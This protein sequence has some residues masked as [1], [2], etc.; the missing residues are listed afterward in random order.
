MI[1]VC[2]DPAGIC[3]I[4]R[5]YI[6]D[7][8][9]LRDWLI[10]EYGPNGFA[11][12]TT[13][14]KDRVAPEYEI[15]LEE[16]ANGY[17]IDND[18]NIIIVHTPQGTIALF[19]IAVVVAVVAVSL[20]SIPSVPEFKQPTESPNNNLSG[21]TNIARPQQRI[22]DVYGKNKVFPD[23]I[24]KTYFEFIN[25][26]KVQNEFMCIG[27]GEYLVE[28]E[29]T[30]NSL[31]AGIAG[32]VSTIFEPFTAPSQLLDV[33]ASNEVNGQ[34]IIGPN[35]AKVNIGSAVT[36]FTDSSTIKSTDVTMATF[37]EM[38]TSELFDISS[39]SVDSVLGSSDI[40]F[41]ATNADEITSSGP[42]LSVF[43]IGDI[44][45]ISGTSSNNVNAKILTVSSGVLKC[46]DP[47]TEVAIVFTNETGTSA[48]ITN[49][50]IN[51][52]TFT[53]SSFSQADIGGGV[54]EFTITVTE[55]TFTVL[56]AH[57]NKY[58]S[59]SF[60]SNE[61][62][63]FNVPGNPD[64]VWFDIQLPKGLQ[65]EGEFFTINLTL[66]LQQIDGGGSPIGTAEDTPIEITENTIDPLFFTFKV[67]PLVIG[68]N[69]IYEASV[70]RSTN[71]ISVAGLSEQTKW[72]RLA[73]V[74]DV[75]VANFGNVTTWFVTTRATEQ[76]TS[77]QER[78][79]NAVVTRK[80]PT[81]NRATGIMTTTTP[82]TARMADAVVDILTNSFMGNK[83]LAQ[84]D[85]VGLYDIQDDLD[86]DVIYGDALGRFCYSFSNSRTPVDDEVNT[87]LRACRSFKFQEGNVI[88][89]GR[90]QLNNIRTT[91]FNRRLKKPDSESKTRKLFKP[92][93]FDGIS[94]EWVDE[95]TGEGETIV[96]PESSTPANP[97]RLE[98]AGVKNYDQAW[99]LGLIN[100]NI[101]QLRRTSVDTTIL[102][103]AL[104]AFPNARVGNVDSTTL[105]TQD[106][107]IKAINGLTVTTVDDIDFQGF[108]TSTVI[109]RD[110]SGGAS[111]PIVVTEIP[112]DSKGFILSSLPSFNIFIR[113]DILEG[114]AIQMGTLYDFA[115]DSNHLANDYLVQA[116]AP[117]SDGYVNVKLLNYDEDVYIPDTTTPTPRS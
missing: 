2:N 8:T 45:Q 36:R 105:K 48:A 20:V 64:Q 95:N 51:A 10:E 71:T 88:K 31:L 80:L 91:T 109:L 33:T 1:L 49:T 76:A 111:N 81:F 68:D 38:V 37:E 70:L 114:S 28:E 30:G 77:I 65:N 54:T 26:V 93:D 103:D 17:P 11:V 96:F 101:L 79:F 116:I 72:T 102:E 18:D 6:A 39:P 66:R 35:V 23:L 27:R 47:V 63:P 98:A 92:N 74:E 86:S 29:K 113:G 90:D 73:G 25:Q 94:L 22:P 52:G 43:S 56:S 78:K 107:E 104:L 13:I 19:I 7:D 110:K 58:V 14:F 115:P 44:I 83:P 9:L 61:I 46:V 15:K 41:A 60:K 100:F 59:Q 3:D 53:F 67:I 87:A 85:L 97:Q 57:P 40:D 21:Q 84:I 50:V 55:T 108:T 89:F 112:G 75:T 62:G 106:G 5:H 4:Q 117:G 69:I 12:P 16:L 24:A 99:N 42:N 82:P 32:T 34:D